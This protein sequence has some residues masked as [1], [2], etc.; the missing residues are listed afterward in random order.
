MCFC[1]DSE[2]AEEAESFTWGVLAGLNSPLSP[3]L[4]CQSQGAWNPSDTH[5][6]DDDRRSPRD[7]PAASKR[8][9]LPVNL[10]L[11]G[12]PQPAV[13]GLICWCSQALGG[14]SLPQEKWERVPEI[15]GPVI[16]PEVWMCHLR[17]VIET[18]LSFPERLLFL[19]SNIPS[20]GS[21]VTEVCLG[22]RTQMLYFLVQFP[23]HHYMLPP[24]GLRQKGSLCH[25][26]PH[27]PL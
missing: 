25:P 23:F 27:A 13:T 10:L 26:C 14:S 2:E 17:L 6:E 20:P 24:C 9:V 11:K 1:W 3:A 22:S 12:D 7:S 16:K 21:A 4:S 18:G 15:R 5:R 19:P 8:I